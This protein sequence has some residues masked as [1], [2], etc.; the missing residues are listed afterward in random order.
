M[1]FP[2]WIRRGR[3]LAI[4][5]VRTSF[6]SEFRFEITKEMAKINVEEMP[7]FRKHDIAAVSITDT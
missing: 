2:Q 5:E 3:A 4:N 7:C 1:P 6:D